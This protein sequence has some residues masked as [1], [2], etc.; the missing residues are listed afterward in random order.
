MS[1]SVWLLMLIY[2]GASLNWRLNAG[3]LVTGA[4]GSYY[5]G[6]AFTSITSGYVARRA[7][8]ADIFPILE[9]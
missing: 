4:S 3:V 1:L 7:T 2:Q 9:G 8:I 6:R 5:V